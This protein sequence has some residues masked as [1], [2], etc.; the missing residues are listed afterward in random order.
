MVS[1]H[2]SGGEAFN[3][4]SLTR[5]KKPVAYAVAQIMSFIAE[6]AL[7]PQQRLYPAN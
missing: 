3:E 4:R 5:S 2:P 6:L 1:L 7:I